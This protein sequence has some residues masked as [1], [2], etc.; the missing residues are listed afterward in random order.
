LSNLL[1]AKTQQMMSK[2]QTPKEY[3]NNI[4][5]WNETMS[6]EQTP[7]N[8]DRIKEIQNETGLPNSVSVQQAL[9]KVW[10]ECE[11]YHKQ[12][13]NVKVLEALERLKVEISKGENVYNH[14]EI[15]Q[16]IEIEITEVKPDND[17]PYSNTRRKSV[18]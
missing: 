3:R 14:L 11:Q 7:M 17:R 18:V 12:Q 5:Y 2:E 4:H 13:T 10:N 15:L 9:L 8:S 16:L 6:K 1:F